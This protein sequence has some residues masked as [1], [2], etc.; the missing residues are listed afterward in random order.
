MFIIDRYLLRLFFRVL[1]ICFCSLTGL[2]I[3]IDSFGNLEEFLTQGEQQGLMR[4]LVDYYGARSLTFF[5]R[6]SSLLILIAAMFAV[7]WLNRS[8]E[9]T[10]LIA[11]GI[12]QRRIIIPLI[13]AGLGVTILAAVNREVGIPQVRDK[14]T[15]S[16]QNWAGT[17]GTT[18]EPRFDNMTDLLIGGQNAFGDKKRIAHPSIGLPPALNGLGTQIVAENAFYQDETADHPKGYLLDRVESPLS[19]LEQPSIYMDEKTVIYTPIDAPWLEEH[20]CFVASD[21]TFDELAAT[22]TI[23]QFSSTKQLIMGLHNPSLDYGADT[24]VTI[25]A[26]IVQPMLDMILLILGLPIVLTRENRNIFIAAGWGFLLVGGFFIV[27]MTCHALGANYLLNPT[28][29]AW[30]PLAIFAPIAAFNIHKIDS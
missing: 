18:F 29:S 20:Q 13:L 26:R 8:N 27:I 22:Q 5:D 21:L 19:L 24:R 15:R 9:M 12:S 3:V 7:T 16:A 1:L 17:N 28:L 23:R 25:H 2:F 6:T 4:V 10:A 14:L 11:A 30:L